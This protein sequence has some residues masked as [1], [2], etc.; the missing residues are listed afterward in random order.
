[1]SGFHTKPNYHHLD[2]I[3]INLTPTEVDWLD[4]AV[5][6][7]VTTLE[8]AEVGLSPKERT[9][10]EI[11]KAIWAR[12]KKWKFLHQTEDWDVVV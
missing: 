2:F 6:E 8:R 5:E 10:L 11:A 3:S 4:N 7:L 1:M 12:T 9:D